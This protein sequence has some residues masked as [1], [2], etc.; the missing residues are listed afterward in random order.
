M[1]SNF[2]LTL[3]LPLFFLGRNTCEQPHLKDR[4][5]FISL[6]VIEEANCFAW[7]LVPL[8]L[9]KTL[10]F[11]PECGIKVWRKHRHGLEGWRVTWVRL[12]LH[13]I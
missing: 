3:F 10:K 7:K 6:T 11:E 1:E 2:T 13:N 4:I 12:I 5:F 9:A 8:S